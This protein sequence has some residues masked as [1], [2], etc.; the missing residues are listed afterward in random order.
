MGKKLGPRHSPPRVLASWLNLECFGV[1]HVVKLIRDENNWK[2]PPLTEWK[3]RP[4]EG[5]ETHSELTSESV[6]PRPPCFPAQELFPL[7][8]TPPRKFLMYHLR[9]WL[10][11]TRKSGLPHNTYN[12][13]TLRTPPPW[14]LS[15]GPGRGG[16][17]I[18]GISVRQVVCCLPGICSKRPAG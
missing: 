12:L 2:D 18:E 1:C 3:L 10:F 14:K 8:Q 4:P 15:S 11:S 17:A 13:V 7:C 16:G 6:E 5:P 9:T